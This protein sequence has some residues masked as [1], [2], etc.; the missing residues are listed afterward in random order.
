MESNW[1]NQVDEIEWQESNGREWNWI[2]NQIARTKNLEKKKK[3]EK[4][5]RTG[6]LIGANVEVGEAGKVAERFRDRSWGR[7]AR[8]AQ[9]QETL[10]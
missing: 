4:K 10:Q 2:S 1:W 6:E 9:K 3:K 7:Q 5:K 8:A